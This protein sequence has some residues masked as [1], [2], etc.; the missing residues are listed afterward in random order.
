[1]RHCNSCGT[2]FEESFRFCPNCGSPLSAK[3]IAVDRNKVL[4][5]LKSLPGYKKI[6]R[7]ITVEG[8]DESA[9]FNFIM[10]HESGVFA[11]QIC[12]RY[13]FVQGSDRQRYWEV[14]D[15]SNADS[16]YMIERPVASL[17]K[18]HRI[19]DQALRRHI[20]A[21]TFAYLIYP[22]DAGL[23]RVDSKHLDQMLTLSRMTAI[24]LRAIDSYGH[25]HSKAD[26]DRLY[27][28]FTRALKN[29]KTVSGYAGQVKTKTRKTARVFTLVLLA[30]LI[31]FAGF[32][33]A[34]D[35]KISDALPRFS[36]R[37]W[38]EYFP[39]L[40]QNTGSVESVDD[41]VVFVVPS[42]YSK[43][44][45]SL[46]QELLD[47]AAQQIGFLSLSADSIGKDALLLCFH[48]QDR[49]RILTALWDG[50]ITDTERI[51]QEE[52]F[53]DFQSLA[54]EDGMNYTILIR[55]RKLADSEKNYLL[56]VF[57]FGV[58][59]A[60]L[61]ERSPSDIKIS[62]LNSSGTVLRVTKYSDLFDLIA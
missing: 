55:S 34:T 35:G 38:K 39:D 25:A 33:T 3:E 59:Y 20:Y 21:R 7:N 48:D 27:N 46:D 28:I 9:D 57:R 51:F 37:S 24:L 14:E 4:S 60:V 6:L 36:W 45:S 62:F 26:I 8:Y 1:M 17:E 41:T 10:L 40:P 13:R 44:Y 43:L 49:D 16:S 23:D 56:E 47:K 54:T 12:E 15:R 2:D 19:L 61:T 32:Y 58:V 11:F 53:P 5:I 18:D 42:E 29:E 31:G 52:N 30:L 22:D 50:F